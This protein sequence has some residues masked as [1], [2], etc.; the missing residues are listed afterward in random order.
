[1][2]SNFDYS[3][4]ASE[5]PS[6]TFIS[7]PPFFTNNL[8]FFTSI[9]P[10]FKHFITSNNTKFLLLLF[11]LLQIF[12]KSLFFN[13]NKISFPDIFID[14]ERPYKIHVEALDLEGNPFSKDLIGFHAR[15]LMH[16]ND[17]IN[18]RLMIDRISAEERKQI[19]P[20]LQ[21]IKN[22]PK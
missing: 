8:L 6:F 14:V 11:S 2:I 10:N 21:E 20:L 4:S 9:K 3:K 22:K 15:E 12:S 1:M 17:H 5:T 18:A 16:E 19:E 7:S 13:C